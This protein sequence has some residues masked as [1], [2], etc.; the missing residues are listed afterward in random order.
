MHVREARHE[1]PASTVDDGERLG[2]GNVISV[3][4]AEDVAP[5]DEHRLIGN[6]R[7]LAGHGQDA[8]AHERGVPSTDRGGGRWGSRPTACD[9]E[10]AEPEHDAHGVGRQRRWYDHLA[11]IGRNRRGDVPPDEAL[12]GARVAT[13][14]R[15]GR[16]PAL[17]AADRNAR[18]Q[19]LRRD[20]RTE[21]LS[22]PRLLRQ[23]T[24]SRTAAR[25]S[26]TS[27]RTG[28]HQSRQSPARGP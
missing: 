4:D 3:P 14:G 9:Q 7:D 20:R 2:H 28:D 5:G 21:L 16:H 24:G 12:L 10:R 1:V 23:V 27:W 15:A 13:Q 25:N 11:Q 22:R 19:L 8:D 18:S 17:G 6:R 26:S